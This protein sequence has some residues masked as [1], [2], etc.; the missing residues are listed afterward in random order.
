MNDLVFTPPMQSEVP[1]AAE[2][3][4]ALPPQVDPPPASARSFAFFDRRVVRPLSERMLCP[5][6][7]LDLC[8]GP[9]WLGFQ[10]AANGH[11]AIA[12][13]AQ[14]CPP[15]GLGVVEPLIGTLPGRMKRLTAAFEAMPLASGS[16]DLAV[17]NGVLD[18]RLDLRLA[19]LEAIRVVR[20]GGRLALLEA[21]FGEPLTHAALKAASTGS[22]LSWRLRRTPSRG[23]LWV[24]ERP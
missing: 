5:L 6:T 20:P 11:A 19:L 21:L 16:V 2:P 14:A 18:Q 12:L 7:V 3:Q 4:R 10:L 15:E 17:F 8:A 22:G 1:A 13:S 24:S 23:D 9:G